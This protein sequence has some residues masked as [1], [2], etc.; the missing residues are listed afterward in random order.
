MAGHDYGRDRMHMPLSTEN[1]GNHGHGY[2][3][4]QWEGTGPE[5]IYGVACVRPP[6]IY[7]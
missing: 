5:L 1:T 7:P 2:E 3:S 4:Q 6:T